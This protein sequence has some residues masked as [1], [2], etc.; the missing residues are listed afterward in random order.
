VAPDRLI[1]YSLLATAALYLVVLVVV[2]FRSWSM[3]GVIAPQWTVGSKLG[4]AALGASVGVTLAGVLLLILK[5][6]TGEPVTDAGVSLLVGER[7]PARTLLAVLVVVVAAPVVEEMLFRGLLA[8]GL[9]DRGT[10]VAV[11]ASAAAFSA[12]HLQ[13]AQFRYYAVI[14]ALLGLLYLR[15]GLIASMSAHAAFNGLLVVVA[16]AVA[17][18]PARLIEANGVTVSAPAQ[19]KLSAETPL[20]LDLALDG[21][22][23]AALVVHH[24][25]LPADVV[26]TPEAVL[27]M[28]ATP[29][30]FL[31]GLDLVLPSARIED[32]PFGRAVRLDV[33]ADGQGGQLVV[34]PMGRR[35]WSI[36]LVDSGS[37]RAKADF[38]RM[39]P[40]L[41]LP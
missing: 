14:G 10:K 3:E 22:S 30:E 32:L 31:P 1:T 17:A 40:T 13:P 2:F 27:E 26:V 20:N 16:I 19:W 12:W 6:A 8:E 23:G 39:L 21:P 36:V 38:A 37:N 5:A 35:V 18:G 41:R 25:D 34:V 29:G 33:T 4:S 28:L 9:R 11:W 24:E 7:D 15:R